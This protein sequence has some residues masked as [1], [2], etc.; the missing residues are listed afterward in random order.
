MTG[1][2]VEVDLI[3]SHLDGSELFETS[4]ALHIL[5]SEVYVSSSKTRVLSLSNRTE[6]PLQFS[7][8][9]AEDSPFSI[10]QPAGWIEAESMHECVITFTPKE[11]GKARVEATFRLHNMPPNRSTKDFLTVH[12]VGEAPPI[13]LTVGELN[14]E[15]PIY[16]GQENISTLSI[17]VKQIFF[18]VNL[19][20]VIV[21]EHF[22]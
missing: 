9:L 10:S 8:D 15:E 18:G 1:V 3:A 13:A 11:V 2:G 12:L 22:N 7:W 19:L 17:K 20:C 6:L 21:T 4:D 5:F 14:F 16:V